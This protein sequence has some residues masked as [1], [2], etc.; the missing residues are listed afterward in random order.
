MLNSDECKC[1]LLNV[2]CKSALRVLSLLAILAALGLVCLL[3]DSIN[4]LPF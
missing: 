2:R 3:D 1:K 4:I